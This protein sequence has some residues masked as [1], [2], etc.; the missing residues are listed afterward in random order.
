[1]KCWFKTHLLCLKIVEANDFIADMANKG[2]MFGQKS[3][4]F[5][6]IPI[7]GFY[8]N[9]YEWG[10]LPPALTTKMKVCSIL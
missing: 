1:M 5:M 10:G 3:M 8:Q 9:G 4:I 7:P 6:P 2:E